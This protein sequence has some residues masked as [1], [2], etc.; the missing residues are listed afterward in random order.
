LLAW[1]HQFRQETQAAYDRAVDSTALAT[2]QGFPLFVAWGT[3]PQ[4]WARTQQEQWAAG[5]ATMREG[6]AA[7]IATGSEVFHPYFLALLAEAYGAAGQP[8]EGLRLLVEA[9]DV[10][11]RTG[12]RFYEAELYRLTGVLH[13]AHAPAAHTEAESHMR[14]A[15]D[16]TRHQQAKAL[17][18]RAALS[19]S[20]LWKRQ[21]KCGEAR[22]LLAPIYAWF[23]E[24][25]NTTDLQEAKA[26]LDELRTPEQCFKAIEE[27]QDGQDV[28]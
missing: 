16:I 6:L 28:E 11:V 14:H 13:L 2:Q 15:L 12:E 17:E 8:A 10:V 27:H 18:L 1:L 25:F 26:L 7:A 3:V 20:R 19:L 22:E 4:G 21:G 5:M 23:T 9:L 24:G